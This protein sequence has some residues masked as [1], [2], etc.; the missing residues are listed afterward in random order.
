M[1][2]EEELAEAVKSGKAFK[3]IL[4]IRFL[5]CWDSIAFALYRPVL[6]NLF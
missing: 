1:L 2:S 4:E 5:W 6:S 3:S